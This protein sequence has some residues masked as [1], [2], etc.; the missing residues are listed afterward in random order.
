LVVEALIRSRGS[1]PSIW[2]VPG[3]I[4]A[5]RAI[6]QHGYLDARSY[7][8]TPR[9]FG[10]HG[11]Y[12]RLA[13][14]LGLVDVHLRAGPH[15]EGLLD[16]W[17][18]G[19]GYRG[20]NGARAMILH[21]SEAVGRSLS[22]K[23]PRTPPN[24]H[25]RSW[26]DL[27]A[28]TAPGGA[29]ARERH[30]L[31]DL[32]HVMDDRR[33]GALHTIWKLQS[34]FDFDDD[35]FPE[36][37]LHNRVAKQEPAYRRLLAAIRAYERFARSLQDAFDVLAAE[38]AQGHVQGYPVP[39]IAYDPDF[40]S[41]VRG[42]DK[43]FKAA[44]QAIDE[45]ASPRTS[46]VG[47]LD[48]RFRVFSEPLDAGDVALA[49]CLHHETVQRQKSVDGKRPWFDRLGKDGIYIRHAYRQPRRPIEPHRYVHAY[50]GRPI[51]RFY[52]DLA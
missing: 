23:S 44:R 15:A 33:L 51:R 35:D 19:L 40:R 32:L 27:A 39:M 31:R 24:W 49:L 16:A 6:G 36:E 34:D 47:L 18:R 25:K 48:A 3:T 4:V 13:T 28:A 45:I 41:S 29:K 2:G 30:Y 9:I 42:L 50:R 43:R 46:L 8:K 10:F 38:A 37:E 17:A 11:V 20:L 22:E 7:L 5:R 52:Q 1:D 12:K 26:A 14:H 21:W